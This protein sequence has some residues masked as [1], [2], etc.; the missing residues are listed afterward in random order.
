VLRSCERSLKTR[1]DA[2]TPSES[3]KAVLLLAMMRLPIKLKVPEPVSFVRP[4]RVKS[5]QAVLDSWSVERLLLIEFV[6]A[7][8]RSA[9]H[10]GLVFHPAVGWMNLATTLGFLSVHLRHHE[11]Q[12]QSIKKACARSAP[13]EEKK[14]LGSR[15]T[16][17]KR[18]VAFRP[19]T[20]W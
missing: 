14:A 4:D 11:Y 12:L 2:V 8:P 15:D 1:R 9:E 6:G 10:V 20:R 18:N 17:G 13:L 16:R 19:L 7:F 3:V 5:L